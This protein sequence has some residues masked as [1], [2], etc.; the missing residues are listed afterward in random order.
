M[1]ELIR[2][3][4]LVIPVFSLK[5]LECAVFVRHFGKDR[6]GSGIMSKSDRVRYRDN[7]VAVPLKDQYVIGHSRKALCTI[8]YN[9]FVHKGS[10]HGAH[11][12]L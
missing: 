6:N 7:I 1:A 11:T 2:F 10:D 3:R 5:L 12:N 8:L 4:I 9:K